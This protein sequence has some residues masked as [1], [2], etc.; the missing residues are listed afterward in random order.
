MD[1]E[2]SSL[3]NFWFE[4]STKQFWFDSTPEFDAEITTKFNPLLSKYNIS[5]LEPRDLEYISDRYKL[6]LGMIILFD[7]IPRHIYRLN[8]SGEIK[9]YLDSIVEFSKKFYSKKLVFV[10]LREFHDV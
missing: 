9:Q 1:S 2:L 3:V 7:Q 8:D 5:T 6:S 4:E 10:K